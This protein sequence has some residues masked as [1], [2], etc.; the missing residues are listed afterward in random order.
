MTQ[1]KNK[2]VLNQLMDLNEME[3]KLKEAFGL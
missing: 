1:F 3:T 2:I